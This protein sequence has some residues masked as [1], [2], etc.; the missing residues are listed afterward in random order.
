MTQ[1][2]GSVNANSFKHKISEVQWSYEFSWNMKNIELQ[3][4]PI[5]FHINAYTLVEKW[6]WYLKF[7]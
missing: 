6:T 2:H 5:P 3:Q 7:F 1:I 4:Y